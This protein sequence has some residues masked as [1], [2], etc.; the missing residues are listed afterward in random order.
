MTTPRPPLQSLWPRDEDVVPLDISAPAHPSTNGHRAPGATIAS[1]PG[2]PP[3]LTAADFTP[4]RMLRPRKQA[5][6]DGWRR[7]VYVLSGGTVA[8]PPSAAEL[9]RRELVAQVTTPISGCRTVAFVS[10]KGGVGKTTTCLLVGHTLALHRGDRIAAIDLNPDA[11]TLGYRLRRET[12]ETVA[13]LLRD[14]QAID[15]YADVRAYSSQAP[16]RLEVIAGDERAEVA[17]AIGSARVGEAV[18]LLERHY[19]VVCLDSAPGVLSAAA[20]GVL[21]A[22]DQL[23]VVTS[24]S[25]DGA[26]SSS[27]TLDWLEQQGYESLASS[28]VAVLNGIRSYRVDLDLRRIEEH[29]A[30]RCRACIDIPWDPHLEIGAEVEL[31]ELRPG[32]R[33]AYLEL[34]AAVACAF[35]ERPGRRS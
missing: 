16:S 31:D 2:R 25:L 1:P 29:F 26:R 15:R 28:A 17:D 7:A 19:N 18:R 34:A 13:T 22:A 12:S 20:R 10:R 4:E 8:V 30:S 3:R 27:L 11:G 21:Q 23:V 32:T 35:A 24:P 33:D 6:T 14:R 9:R 5:P